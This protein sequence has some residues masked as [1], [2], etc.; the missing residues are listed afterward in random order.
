[1]AGID[2]N[3]EKLPLVVD[4]PMLELIHTF[5]GR[6]PVCVANLVD[7]LVQHIVLT[8]EE[9][10]SKVTIAL[11]IRDINVGLLPLCHKR[12]VFVICRVE[13]Q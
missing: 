6:N 8:L 5:R 12:N 4:E 1:M 7:I 3:A 9:A 11:G 2:M 13:V 10:S